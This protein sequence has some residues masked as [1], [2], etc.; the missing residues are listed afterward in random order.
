MHLELHRDPASGRPRLELTGPV[1]QEDWQNELV[2]AAANTAFGT[3]REQPTVARAM[4]LTRD[5]MAVASQLAEASW[6]ARPTE[7]SLAKPAVITA[8]TRS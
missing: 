4:E 1:F 7:P 5:A 8:A 2:T 6:R 3:M